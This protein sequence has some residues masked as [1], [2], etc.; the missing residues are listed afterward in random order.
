M[1]ITRRVRVL[2]AGCAGAA[3]LS[4]GAAPAAAI[5]GGEEATGA[6][7]FMASLQQRAD[8]EHFCGG[9]LVAPQWILTA[10]HCLVDGEGERTDPTSITVRL[11]SN[12]RTQG[13]EV[14]H[15]ERIEASAG[16]EIYG[17]DVALLRLDA[18]V[19][20]TPAALPSTEL[21][22]GEE[23][24]ALGWG[25]HELPENPGDP[26]PPLP[27]RLRQLD[28]S[29]LDPDRCPGLSGE[30]MAD[31]ELCMSSLPGEGKWPQTTRTG[32]SGGPL[33]TQVDGEWTVHGTCS[34]GVPDQHG[35]FGSVHDSREWILSM[36]GG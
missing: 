6:Y 16:G 25:S 27:E 36:I 13:G 31:N 26:W 4:G 10:K 15:G 1:T 24:R 32:D 2:V 17:Q 8:G 33:L 5:S 30:P 22:P 35:I 29:I 3:L 7:P 12:D 23:V 34:R 19:T 9:T 11:G 14:R 21:E 18:P 20:A 28:T